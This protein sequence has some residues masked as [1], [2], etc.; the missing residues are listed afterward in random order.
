MLL[1]YSEESNAVRE[2]RSYPHPGE[3][4]HISPSPR[5]PSLAFTSYTTDKGEGS[6]ECALWRLPLPSASVASSSPSASPARSPPGHG[7][8]GAG[9]ASAASMGR[10]RLE[11]L[12]S[13]PKPK[14]RVRRWVLE[15]R[16]SEKGA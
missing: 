9:A 15:A 7:H 16:W 3:I 6:H 8:G 10:H 4:W 2:A 1:E 5:D 14:G 12:A 13:L 11:S